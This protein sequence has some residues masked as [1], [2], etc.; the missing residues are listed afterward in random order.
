MVS[1][2]GP[3]GEVLFDEEHN[4]LKTFDDLG[5][6]IAAGAAAMKDAFVQDNVSTTEDGCFRCEPCGKGGS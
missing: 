4:G 2:V 3:G 1:I 5:E 6:K